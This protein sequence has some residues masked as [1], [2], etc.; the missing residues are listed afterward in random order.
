MPRTS[1]ATKDLEVTQP[2]ARTQSGTGQA[3]ISPEKVNSEPRIAVKSRIDKEWAAN[4]KFSAE[5]ITVRVTDSN[6]P[7]AEK[8]VTVWNNGERMDFMR[9]QDVTCERRFVE[10]LARAKPTTFSQKAIMDEL[11]KPAAMQEIPH[12]AL[13][14]HFQVVRDDNPLGQAWLK[15]ILAQQ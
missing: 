10:T 15:S 1:V 13:R 6:E 2:E 12:R 9:G 8:V 7:N 3:A 14:Y 11:G 4:M 5:K